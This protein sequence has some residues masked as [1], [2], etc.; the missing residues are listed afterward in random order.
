MPYQDS[1]H[2]F[3]SFRRNFSEPTIMDYSPTNDFM[4]NISRDEYYTDNITFDC[5][6]SDCQEQLQMLVVPNPNDFKYPWI[7]SILLNELHK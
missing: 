4:V 6:S 2:M 1:G 7:V 5:S 3:N